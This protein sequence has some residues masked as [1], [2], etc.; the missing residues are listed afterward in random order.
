[1]ELKD[2]AKKFELS[3]A[4]TGIGIPKDEEN[5]LFEKFTRLDNAQK[6]RPDGTGIG[7]YTAKVIVESHGGKIWFKSVEG[8][9]T[10][11]FVEMPKE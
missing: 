2:K 5:K 10:T 7:L 6:I 4:D 1:M 3:V 9:G 8:K 11:F